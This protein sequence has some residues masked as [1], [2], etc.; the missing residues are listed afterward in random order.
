MNGMN[1][2]MSQACLPTL[3]LPRDSGGVA[4]RE[5]AALRCLR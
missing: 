2:P 5:G 3:V 1:D 4:M